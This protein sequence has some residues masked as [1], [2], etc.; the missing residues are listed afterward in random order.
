VDNVVKYM[1][2]PYT[3][4]PYLPRM[5]RQTV[6]LIILKGWSIRKASRHVG[7]CPSTV[8]RW[9]DK[10]DMMNT[11]API[12]TLSSRPC[13][14]PDELSQEIIDEIVKI[15][16]KHHRC[17]EVVYQEL[18][19]KG[20]SVSLSSVK[21]TLERQGLIRKRSPWKRW[22]F[23]IE[24]PLALNPGSL[25]QIDTIHLMKDPKSRM[26]IYTLIDVFSRWTQARFSERINTHKSL[27]FAIDSQ[28]VFPCRFN[29]IQSDHGQEFSS[30]FTEHIKK[31]D[32]AHRHS[33][34]RKP[35]DNGHLERF[36][37]TLQEECLDRIPKTI[38]AMKKAI[39]EYIHYYNTERL[40]LGLK[41]KTP[42]Q[43]LQSY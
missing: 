22:H 23:E 25:V 9:L 18:L 28:R 19:N 17:A 26:Y 27:R 14:H 16:L 11:G 29:M 43:V 34:V 2:I 3:N 5:R 21:R 20:I 32:I 7:V 31:K 1:Y 35:S 13:H 10:A 37:R 36:N 8:K 39:P 38:R 12:P 24:R 40:H 42:Q 15:R 4:N 30:W 6:N 33:R 41:L